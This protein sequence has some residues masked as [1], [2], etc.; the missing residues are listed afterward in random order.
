MSVNCRLEHALTEKNL[1]VTLYQAGIS[2]KQEVSGYGQKGL[3]NESD[4]FVVECLDQ[5]HGSAVTGTTEVNRR[6]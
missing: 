5:E 1:H 3:G 4:D 6:N 2:S